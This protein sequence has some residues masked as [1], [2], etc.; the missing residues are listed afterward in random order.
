MK[1]ISENREEMLSNSFSET[2]INLISKPDKDI[3]RKELYRPIIPWTKVY[4][5]F[6]KH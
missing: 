5:L 6:M 2:G 4:K 3:I 1:T